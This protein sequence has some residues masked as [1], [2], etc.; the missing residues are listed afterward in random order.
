[1]YRKSFFVSFPFASYNFFIKMNFSNLNFLNQC[2]CWLLF[3]QN[4]LNYDSYIS[5]CFMNNLSKLH[6][7]AMFLFVQHS[8]LLFAFMLFYV[9]IERSISAGATC[10]LILKYLLA[11]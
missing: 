9:L 10:Q 6:F 11:F 4:S 5:M 3:R 7:F 1:M 8:V 2:I